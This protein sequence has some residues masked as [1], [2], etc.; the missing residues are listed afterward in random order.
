[1]KRVPIK[2]N[3]FS[4]AHKQLRQEINELCLLLQNEL[5]EKFS[6]INLEDKLYNFII[7]KS[8]SYCIVF[9]P[10]TY[11]MFSIF[12]NTIQLSDNITNLVN[13]IMSDLSFQTLDLTDYTTD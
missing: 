3:N 13:I 4:Y 9:S 6:C 8:S 10:D 12:K 11:Y 7:V 1:M 2:L 5:N